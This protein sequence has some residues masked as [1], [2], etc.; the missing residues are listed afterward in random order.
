M[1]GPILITGYA[2]T[3]KTTRAMGLV[4]ERVTAAAALEHH[5]L[6][7]MSFMHGARRRLDQKLTEVCGIFPYRATT[8]DAFAL[9]ILNRW[10]MSLGFSKPFSPKTG[11]GDLA[12]GL[13]E[14][15]ASFDRIRSEAAKLLSTQTV[16]R[17]IGLSFP[18]IVVDEFQD[19]QG[20]QLEIVK[21]LANHTQLL[22]AADDFQLLNPIGLDCPAVEW[23]QELEKEGKAVVEDLTTPRR[24][25]NHALLQAARCLRDNQRSS[26][27]TVPV[28]CCPSSPLAASWIIRNIAM[29]PFRWKGSC[30]V[31]S[32]TL[33]SF[34]K[35]TLESCNTQLLKKNLP[36]VKFNTEMSQENEIKELAQTLGISAGA[37]KDWAQNNANDSPLGQHVIDRVRHYCRLRGIKSIPERL[38]LAFA[39]RT[40]STQRAY[41]HRSSNRTV[42]TIH[43]TKNREFE[44]V[45]VLWNSHTV[46]RWSVDEQR[47]LLY[48]AITRA[49]D[50]CLVLVLGSE[51]SAQSDPVL[52]L[53]GPPRPAFAKKPSASKKVRRSKSNSK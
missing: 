47:R 38:V 23:V 24:T 37:S 48:N 8:I 25:T 49:K 7:G 46:G 20:H 11:D 43:G 30:A 44:N 33:D 17:V 31:V 14:V 12:E 9:S 15:Q 50:N 22:L 18:L 6:L 35:K 2:G 1:H 13:F 26:V 28:I 39:E 29:P 5:S 41:G 19:C 45:F 10:R 42:S 3:G 32:P 36:A 40:V 4:E 51:E 27:S 34:V 53:L 52:N 16:G 21:A